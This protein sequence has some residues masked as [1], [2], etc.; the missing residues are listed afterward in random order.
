M[1]VTFVVAIAILLGLLLFLHNEVRRPPGPAQWGRVPRWPKRLR[2]VFAAIIL[3]LAG[4]AFWGF[5]IEPGRLVVHE[6]T[7]QIDNWPPPLD[8]LRIA[9]ISDLH[10][11][12]RF[13]TEK[14]LRT[15]VARTNEL[16]PDLIV[17]LGDY[18][19]GAGRTT[20][21]VEP[22]VFGPILKDFRA[23]LGVYSVLGNHDWWY[24]GAK[25]RK[26]LEQN[27]IKVLENESAKV[28]ARGTSFWLVGLADLWTRPQRIADTVAAVPEGQPVIALTHNPDIFPNVPQRV[29]LVLAGHTHGGQVR[30][31]IIG[32]VISSSEYGNRWVQGHVFE[33]NHHLFVTT[34]I[35]TS[36]V[37]VRFGLPPEIVILTL[38]SG[39]QN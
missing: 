39:S 23:P 1:T 26:A 20:E 10:V 11:D 9:V 21:R 13:I 7:I 19:A 31:P 37:P 36:I 29:Q 16:Q 17:I 34:G 4:A 33:N 8:G 24:S 27:G 30:F 35:G 25:V 3:F 22:E 6:Q 12:N 5:L 18:V 14:K 38:K 28:D 2:V 32:P 15:I